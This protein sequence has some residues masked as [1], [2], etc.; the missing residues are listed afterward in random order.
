MGDG[1]RR[2][3]GEERPNEPGL[4]D[5]EQAADKTVRAE[6]EPEAGLA[7]QD[8]ESRSGHVHDDRDQPLSAWGERLPGKR[9]PYRRPAIGRGRF[10]PDARRYL[11]I[12][13]HAGPGG[14]PYECR[15]GESRIGSPV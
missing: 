11:R 7:E 8:G 4:L 13:V 2:P 15:R 10:W 5:D 6:V 1:T 12:V 14:I 9:V 3:A